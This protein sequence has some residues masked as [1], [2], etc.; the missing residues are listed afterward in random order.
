M[1]DAGEHEGQ[2]SRGPGVRGSFHYDSLDQSP[3]P[4]GRSAELSP[5]FCLNNEFP[6]LR[7]RL[8]YL[9]C[10]LSPQKPT[11]E[12]EKVKQNEMQT[13]SSLTT[14]LLQD[15]VAHPD[16]LTQQGHH[17]GK[18]AQMHLGCWREPASVHLRGLRGRTST[19][20]EALPR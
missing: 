1:P 7:F 10:S 15:S 11:A 16:H 18:H 20:R 17:H 5:H 3:E 12:T 4:G 13:S 9:L 19:L 6:H 2:W 8:N 14:L